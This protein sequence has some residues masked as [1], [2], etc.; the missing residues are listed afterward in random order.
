MMDLNYPNL[1]M[2]GFL[3]PGDI[4]GHGTVG[5]GGRAA[6]AVRKINRLPVVKEAVYFTAIMLEKVGD[7]IVLVVLSNLGDNRMLRHTSSKAGDQ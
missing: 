4:L 6:I 5:P 2:Y 3:R 7:L 1:F